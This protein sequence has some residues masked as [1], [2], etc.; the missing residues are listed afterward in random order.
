MDTL[1][2]VLNSQDTY[3]YVNDDSGAYLDVDDHIML[4]DKVYKV[5]SRTLDIT[6]SKWIIVLE[7]CEI[8][9]IYND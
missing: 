9:R 2:K 1:F 5:H 3:F 7:R 8:R 6:N 4:H